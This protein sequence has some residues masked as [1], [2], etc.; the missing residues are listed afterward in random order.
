MIIVAIVLVFAFLTLGF[1]IV[2]RSTKK[3]DIVFNFGSKY[4]RWLTLAGLSVIITVIVIMGFLLLSRNRAN[5]IAA[6]EKTLEVT[7]E[8]AEA[9][10]DLWIKQGTSYLESLGRNLELAAL[11]NRLLEVNPDKGSL[12]SSSSL[13]DVRK[14]FE[15]KLNEFPNIGFFIIDPEYISIGSKRDGN[16]GSVNLI[17]LEYP[18]ILERAFQGE[19]LFVPPIPS[20]VDL[21]EVTGNEK[22]VSPP[23]MFFIGPVRNNMGDV[24]AVM[25]LRVDPTLEFSQAVQVS[26]AIK[27]SDTYTFSFE[28]VMLSESAFS[29]ELAAIGLIGDGQST[30]L[31]L[32][33]RDP[34]VNLTQG[35]QP[36]L[37]PADQ[38]FTQIAAKVIDS[39]ALDS[40]GGARRVPT[41]DTKGYRDYRGVS[42]FGAGLWKHDIDIGIITEID[43]DES[44]S[45]YYS[46]RLTVFIVL[47]AT[48]F[49]LAGAILF[50]LILG[51]RA[52]RQLVHARDTLE[53][54]VAERTDELET[55]QA[56]L[57]DEEEKSRL[58]LESVGEGIFGVNT[59]GEVSFVNP[60]AEKL[61]EFSQEELL[62]TKI[63]D[64]IHHSRAD[65]SPYPVE[66]CPM[67]A[68]YFDGTSHIVTDEVLWRKNGAYFYVNY[69]STPIRKNGKLVGS[70]VTFLDVSGRKAQEDEIKKLST[71]MEQ[72]PATVVITDP[73]G[74]IEYVNPKFEE[75]TGYA[76]K[77]A[78]GRNPRLLNAGMLPKDF[79]ADL[80][81]TILAGDEWRGEFI[82]KKKDGEIFWES[83]SISP[84]KDERGNITHFIAVKE[85]ITQRK[86]VEEDLTLLNQLVYG[87]LASADVGAW[88]IDFSEEDTFHGLDTTAK[89]IGLP[90]S[91]SE[92]KS[93]KISK[94][95]EVLNR[96]QVLD[97]EYRRIIDE[98]L[99]QFSGT[100]S[101][102][103]E[104]YRATYPVLR[105]D[106]EIK[107][108]VAR[109]DVP[110]RDENNQAL[111]MTGTL[112]D[113][114]EQR[115]AELE[116]EVAK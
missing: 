102:K 89:L 72:S 22:N 58:L 66:Q 62:G 12:V 55:Q 59:N 51:E 67:R 17:A 64:I 114:T 60:A 1:W 3:K 96:T 80:W 20:D 52:N 101:G 43:V 25:T 24:I 42:V 79:F 38:P 33:I 104:S 106:G 45:A 29:E 75:T 69:T 116:L 2:I 87:S 23:T 16:I 88:W 41:T 40:P 46:L 98:T 63:H 47:G 8:N 53:M 19:V 84:L 77:E 115:E 70:V 93:Y 97:H 108:I 73:K 10:L 14:F 95:V 7:L 110:L 81:H 34:G 65:G 92:D 82:N 61:L 86:K 105:P 35:K 113:I 37:E 44:L 56:L 4:F 107:W 68:S 103:Y 74:C 85:D 99:E 21:A 48:I 26:S 91:K 90:V 78:L 36:T 76:A 9:R 15:S 39:S 30:S 112:I 32:E 49:L 11:A 71:A 31:N 83:A 109:A 27:S 5:V 100:I 57:K 28:G 13:A 50:V 111:Q 6:T 18:D 94:W 54:K